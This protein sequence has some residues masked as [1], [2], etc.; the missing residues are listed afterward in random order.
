MRARYAQL[1]VL[2]PRAL[3]TPRCTLAAVNARVA[4]AADVDLVTEII[5]LAFAEDPVWEQALG[6]ENRPAEELFG[7]WR[8]FVLGALRYPWVRL[9]NEGEAAAIWIPPGG[10]ELSE[11]QEQEFGVLATSLL[12][13]E[14][15]SYLAAVVAAFDANHPRDEPHY[16]LSLLGTHPA[17][18]GRGVGMALLAENLARVDAEGMPAYLE[19]SN[20]VNDHRYARMGF[21]PIGEF[22]LPDNGPMVTTMW[23][24]TRTG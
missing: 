12:S 6:G 5:S 24:A 10:T 22:Q 23:R 18:R 15:A 19:S 11:E 8:I 4:T 3:R 14:A 7:F 17:H 16:Y 21:S 1:A 20:P 2:T 9:W 13:E